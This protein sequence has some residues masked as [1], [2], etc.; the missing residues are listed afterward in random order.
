MVTVLPYFLLAMALVAGAVNGNET[1]EAPDGGEA[2]AETP[3][4]AAEPA[5]YETSLEPEAT[6]LSGLLFEGSDFETGSLKGWRLE[7]TAFERQPTLGDNVAVRH[8]T[9]KALIEGE[10]FIGTFENYRGLPGETPGT[11]QGDRMTGGLISP[12][13]TIEEP[14]ITFL[15]GGGFSKHIGVRLIVQ[16]ETVRS[17]TGANSE[18]MRREWWDVTEYV[19]EQGQLYLVDRATDAWGHLNVDDFRYAKAI[20]DT[21]LF[22]NS[23]FE[24]GT[25]KNWFAEGLAFAYQPTKGDTVT[26]RHADYVSNHQ[27]EFW[28]SSYDRYQG[29]D[30][31]S[32][33]DKVGDEATGT[34]TSIPFVIQGDLIVFRIAGGRAEG[35]G[36]HLVVDGEEVHTSR[37]RN[38]PSLELATWYVADL[39]GKTARIR[40][41]DQETGTWGIISADDFYYGRF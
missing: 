10:Y 18:E 3:T 26:L 15:I 24:A 7:G 11:T 37:G 32:P 34:L 38:H 29:K 31:Q 8:S 21:R 4:V 2:K 39:R 30:G 23:D 33:G 9:W 19:G 5:P 28:A 27:G 13:F 35:V 14:Y 36:I 40:I 6:Y 1:V 25:L 22:P 16:G 20:P 41:V 17:A 12:L